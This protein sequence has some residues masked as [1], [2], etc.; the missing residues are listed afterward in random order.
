MKMQFTSRKVLISTAILLAI[1]A[2][3]FIGCGESTE[4]AEKPGD[5]K[6]A[7][8]ATEKPAEKKWTELM[9]F[10][11]SGS[12]KS[13]PFHLSGGK[14]RVKYSFKESEMGIFSFTVVPEGEDD[15]ASLPEAEAEKSETSE[16]Y[17]TKEAGN[18]YIAVNSANGDWEVTV[19][20]EK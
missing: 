19:E 1:S 14:A 7:A 15:G 18:Y 4:A 17:I 16:S 6:E 2:I 13:A 5:A 3:T 12:K 10:K 20:E 11:G 9:S 8:A